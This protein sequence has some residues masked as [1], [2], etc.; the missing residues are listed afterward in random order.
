MRETTNNNIDIKAIEYFDTVNKI[1]YTKGYINGNHYIFKNDIL[2]CGDHQIAN[3]NFKKA[4][5][6]YSCI[7]DDEPIGFLITRTDSKTGSTIDH[8]A[9]KQRIN[10]LVNN[11]PELSKIWRGTEY[12]LKSI[13][14]FNKRKYL[15]GKYESFSPNYKG[16]IDGIGFSNIEENVNY[17]IT[18]LKNG[19]KRYLHKTSECY[20]P[21]SIFLPCITSD[22]FKASDQYRSLEIAGTIKCLGTYNG[23]VVL[24]FEEVID[25]TKYGE[26]IYGPYYVGIDVDELV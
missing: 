6:N 15:K 10:F 18:L 9:N 20:T 7:K 16:N 24:E 19:K 21:D 17:C 12:Y 23:R 4:I 5:D 1:L 26:P 3:D 25:F 8:D 2:S 14:E 22:F 11:I 13:I